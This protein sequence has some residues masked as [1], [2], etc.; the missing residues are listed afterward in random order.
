MLRL[1]KIKKKVLNINYKLELLKRSKVYLIFYVLL[2][3][4]VAKTTNTSSKEVK[5]EYKLNVFKV[6]RILNSKVSKEEHIKYLV[7]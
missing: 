1:Y 2:L 7:K 5:L 3:K 4:E 6:K